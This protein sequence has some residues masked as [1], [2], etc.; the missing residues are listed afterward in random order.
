MAGAE[1]CSFLDPSPYPLKMLA[2]IRMCN[3]DHTPGALG[4]R[5]SAQFGS[6]E[7]GH[8]G[9]N[10]APRDLTEPSRFPIRVSSDSVFR[11]G[12]LMMARF[13]LT[14]FEWSVIEP[15]L[16]TKFA[17]SPGLTTGGC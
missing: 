3:G 12:R 14:D 11:E 16:P 7:L 9:I 4:K 1:L 5:L 17:G 8:N 10:V 2:N 6:A 13:D 15:L